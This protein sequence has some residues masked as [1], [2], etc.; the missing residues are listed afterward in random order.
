MIWNLEKENLIAFI[1]S[2]QAKYGSYVEEF[3]KKN[4]VFLKIPRLLVL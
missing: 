4:N 3:W 1:T 2:K